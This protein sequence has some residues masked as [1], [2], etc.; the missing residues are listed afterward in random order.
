MVITLRTAPS[1]REPTETVRVSYLTSEQADRVSRGEHT[2]WLTTASENFPAWVRRWS[3]V[4]TRWGVPSTVLW[5]CSDEHYLGTLVIRHELTAE[6][7]EAGGH[8]GYHVVLPWQRLGHA[9]RM[10]ADGLERC[11]Q[12]GLNRVLLTCDPTN[13]ASRRTILRNGGV[14][15]G[16]ARGEDRYWIEL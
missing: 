7:A 3:G 11:A 1:L 8:I 6:L 5:Y 15:D 13:E 14:P 12:M 9:T 2:E 16:R 4:Q 10:L